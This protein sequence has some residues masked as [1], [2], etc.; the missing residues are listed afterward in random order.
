ML[1]PPS[2]TLISYTTGN[3]FGSNRYVVTPCMSPSQLSSVSSLSDLR[4]ATHLSKHFQHCLGTDQ[5]R[6]SVIDSVGGD[7]AEEQLGAFGHCPTEMWGLARARRDSGGLL[8]ALQGRERGQEDEEETGGE[9]ERT[10]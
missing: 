6:E 10:G 9:S 4:S 1:V 5:S 2:T 8:G 3:L 7:G